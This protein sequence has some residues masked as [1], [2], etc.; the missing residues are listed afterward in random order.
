M[1][2]DPNLKRPVRGHQV[3]Q[4]PVVRRNQQVQQTTTDQRLLAPEQDSSWTH[5]DPWRVMRIQ[6]EFV[7]GAVALFFHQRDDHRHGSV[8]IGDTSH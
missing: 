2:T 8:A 6:S 5:A 1:M 7:E 4:G 3:V